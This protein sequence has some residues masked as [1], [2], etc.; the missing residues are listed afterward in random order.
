[1]NP[2]TFNGSKLNFWIMFSFFFVK[3]KKAFTLVE[4]V[5]VVGIIATLSAIAV[6]SFET[7]FIKPGK[8]SNY[9]IVFIFEIC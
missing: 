7:L 4:L 2:N 8:R 6:P 3:D 5:V 1:M 9:I